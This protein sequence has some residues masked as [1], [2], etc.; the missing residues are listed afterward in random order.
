[1]P[2]SA[3]I[4]LLSLV[5]YAVYKVCIIAR[6]L[7]SLKDELDTKITKLQDQVEKDIDFVKYAITVHDIK[8]N[9]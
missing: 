3:Y 1:M 2:L 4:V 6:W 8:C 5:V 9:G 7:S